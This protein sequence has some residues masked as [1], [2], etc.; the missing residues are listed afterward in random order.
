[1]VDKILEKYEGMPW[2]THTAREPDN[3]TLEEFLPAMLKLRAAYPM[4][5]G[6]E[7]EYLNDATPD[8]MSRSDYVTSAGQSLTIYRHVEKHE[9]EDRLIFYIHGGGFIRGNGKYSRTNARLHLEKLG[10]PTAC[11][12]YRLA[13]KDREPA[14]LN[15]TAA[16]YRFLV[17]ELKYDPEKILITGDS[18]GGTLALALGRRLKNTGEKMPRAFAFYSPVTNLTMSSISLEINLGKDRLFSTG[19]KSV[20]PMYADENRLE[21]PEVSPLFGDFSGGFPKTYFCADDTEILCSDTLE[22]S[23]KMAKQGVE[24]K[25]HIFHNLWHAFPTLH[26]LPPL[27]KEV[28]EVFAEVKAFFG[29]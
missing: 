15:D 23:A 29:I 2:L 25:T 24:V 20:I 4:I 19:F 22:C 26:S 3:R 17:D 27:P 28:D 14:A 16:A 1:M 13:P 18:A 10:I 11:C 21:S 12:D 5:P 8:G 9:K 6:L 7:M